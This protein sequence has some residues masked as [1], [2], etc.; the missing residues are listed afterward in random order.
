MCNNNLIPGVFLKQQ[1]INKTQRLNTR[2]IE[3]KIIKLI[4]DDVLRRNIQIKGKFL[5]IN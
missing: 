1:I 3:N 5:N 4:K 2:N